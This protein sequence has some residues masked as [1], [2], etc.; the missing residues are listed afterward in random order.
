MNTYTIEYRSNTGVK[1]ESYI[2]DDLRRISFNGESWVE[3]Y[4]GGQFVATLPAH[5]VICISMTKAQEASNG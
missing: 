3:F 2:S 1:V 5:V 4:A